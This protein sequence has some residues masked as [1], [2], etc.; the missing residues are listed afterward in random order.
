MWIKR[1]IAPDILNSIDEAVAESQA[2][3][4]KRMWELEFKP[5]VST[6]SL[7]PLSVPAQAILEKYQSKEMYGTWI[8]AK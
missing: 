1:S 3:Y 8:D 4:L 5:E 2:D 7:K 6:D